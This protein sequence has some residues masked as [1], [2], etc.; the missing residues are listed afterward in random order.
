MI[1]PGSGQGH[2]GQAGDK[3][4][5]CSVQAAGSMSEEVGNDCAHWWVVT[6]G[7]LMKLVYQG[8]KLNLVFVY[9][10]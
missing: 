2:I 1:I 10:H 6:R 5:D 7:G 3:R 8:K 9:L 4:A